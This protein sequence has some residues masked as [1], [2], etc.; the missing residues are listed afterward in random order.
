MEKMIYWGVDSPDKLTLSYSGEVGSS[1]LT[2]TSDPNSGLSEREI[3]IEF[4]DVDGG[5]LGSLRITQE[6]RTRSYG[7]SFR[8][9]YK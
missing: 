9:E 4:T 7:V 8:A 2:V 1:V 6:P 3:V 5:K